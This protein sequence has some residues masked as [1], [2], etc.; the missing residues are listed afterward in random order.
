[1]K[2]PVLGME[3]WKPIPGYAGYEVSSEGR[4]RTYRPKNGRGPILLEPREINPRALVGKPYLRVTLTNDA[5]K[6]VDRKAHVLVLLT[7]RGPAPTSKHQTRHLNGNHKDNRLDNL[8]WGTPQANA[9][10]RIVHGTQLR[11]QDIHISVLTEDQ[12]R[13]IK[14]EIPNWKRGTTATLARKYNVGRS[15]INS[16]RDNITWRHI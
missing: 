10:D 7:F 13:E 6:Q 14:A 5:G 1:M 2:I 16:I 9:Q 12:V 11:G 15:T 3:V 8:V 4:F